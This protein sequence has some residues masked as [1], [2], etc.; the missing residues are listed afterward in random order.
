V[1]AGGDLILSGTNTYTGGTTI[2][3]GTLQ[4]GDGGTNGTIRGPIT[5]N[6]RLIIDESGT[7]EF[8]NPVS[9]SGVL[10]QNGP[11][12]TLI[13]AANSYTGGTIVEAGTL[14]VDNAEALGNGNVDV[15]GGILTADPQSINVPGNY[16]QGPNGTLQL[17][18]AGASPGQ[19]D[20]L[21]VGGNASLGGTLQLLDVNGF[22][23][24][25]GETLTLVKTGRMVISAF[26]HFL[27]PFTP[28][29][30]LTSI[31]LIYNRNSVV[32]EFL[33]QT[34]PPAPPPPPPI[35]PVIT[36]INFPSFAQTPN[37]L[38]A[39]DLLNVVELDPRVANLI[40]YFLQHPFTELPS[41]FDQISTE[42]LTAFL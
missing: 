18:V 37:Q 23:P 2:T 33:N 1:V 25:A 7:F 12:T 35:I 17:E 42:S 39:S 19:Y 34:G 6:S 11:G 36:K 8:S 27:D 10:V 32:L 24:K 4:L 13:S 21:N 26:Q 40:N 29:P 3:G 20:F 38:A 30:G 14:V 28:G 16:F 9:G 41:D 31:E 22:Q 5:N 15:K